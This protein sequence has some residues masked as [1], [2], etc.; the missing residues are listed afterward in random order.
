MRARFEK[1]LLTLH[2]EL[3]E[4][5]SLCEEIILKTFKA[6]E[7]EQLPN[8]KTIATL[9][10]EIEQMEQDIESRCLK[11]LLRQQPVAKDLRTV[12]SAL[13]M[14]YDLKRIGTQAY[15]VSEIVAQGHIVKSKELHV[16]QSM[17]D[18]VREMVTMSIDAFVHEDEALALKVIAKDEE[19]DENFDTIKVLLVECFA[20]KSPDIEHAIDLLM[21]SKYIERIGDHAVNIAKWVLYAITGQLDIDRGE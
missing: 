15:E 21:V 5:G 19:V 11:I 16:L 13:K 17:V 8:T 20:S 4:M 7:K 1:Q 6:I 12:S 9:S 18:S 14:V 2:Q 10:E 3:I